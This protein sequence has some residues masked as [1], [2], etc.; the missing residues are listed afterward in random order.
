ME[1]DFA[2]LADYALT[3]APKPKPSR[4]HKYRKENGIYSD[5]YAQKVS[6]SHAQ[7][8]VSRL[9]R[10]FKLRTAVRFWGAK[11][12][13]MAYSSGLIRL[14]HDP[15]VGLIAHELAHVMD[16]QRYRWKRKKKTRHASKRW[17]WLVGRIIRYGKKRNWW[18]GI[19][20]RQATQK[21]ETAIKNETKK[22]NA[23][24]PEAKVEHLR[25]QLKR[26]T[27]KRK[28]AD[29]AIKKLE[30]RLRIVDRKSSGT[31]GSVPAPDR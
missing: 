15:S 29:T 20:E 27:S 25:E 30:R 3:R 10:H 19:L 31:L 17:L 13:G 6:D 26:W 8:I 7:F 21:A 9:T 11:Q 28:R 24:T 16:A 14:S 18:V 2:T 23:T 4:Y 1:F 5:S 12:S 22:A